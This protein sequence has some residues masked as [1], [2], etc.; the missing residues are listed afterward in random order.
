MTNLG[1][2][3]DSGM[4]RTKCV[5]EGAYYIFDS[6]VGEHVRDIIK[7]NE[8]VICVDR[9]HSIQALK[10]EVFVKGVAGQQVPYQLSLL[11]IDEMNLMGINA[12]VATKIGEAIRN[13]SDEKNTMDDLRTCAG[14]VVKTVLVTSA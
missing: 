11:R 6:L 1:Y 9:E 14:R 7:V 13:T 8:H 2:V 5:G 12:E 4:M 10:K 3:E